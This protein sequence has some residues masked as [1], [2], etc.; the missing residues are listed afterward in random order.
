[1]KTFLTI[2][3][4]L[5][6]LVIIFLTF[7]VS[8]LKAQEF[9]LHDEEFTWHEDDIQYY[10]KGFHYWFDL[11]EAPSTNWRS[12]YDYY[13]GTFNF[14]YELLD[15]PESSPGEYEPFTM[16]FCIWTDGGGKE[17]CGGQIDFSGPRVY[18][19]EE[20]PASFYV[21][22]EED[23]DW[24]DLSTLDRMGHPLWYDGTLLASP[25]NC[26]GLPND[27][28]W[29]EHKDKVF[30]FTIRVTIVVADESGFSGWENYVGG[31]PPA[32]PNY[33]INYY[34]EETQQIV[35]SSDEYSYDESTWY[36]GPDDYLSLTPGVTV[37]FRHKANPG[38]VQTLN[39]PSRPATP[40]FSLDF[41]NVETYEAVSSA[42]EYSENPDM[43]DASDG[44]GGYVDLT[45]GT[46]MYFRK[47]ASSGSFISGIQHLIVPGRPAAPS[48]SISYPDENTSES[49]PSTVQYSEYSDMSDAT[50]GSDSE[51]SL[52][53]GTDLYFRV[54]PTD[55]S[56][57]SENFFLDVPSRPSAPDYTID[58]TNESTN[59]NVPSSDEYSVNSNMSGAVSG[60][61]TKL[62]LTPGTDVYFRTKA[63][64]SAFKSQ[65]KTLTVPDRPATPGFTINPD[66]YETNETVPA[67]TE[68]ST[69]QTDWTA[70]SGT[71]L[72]L[73]SGTTYYFRIPATSGSF[74]SGTQTLVVPS[75]G[76][77]NYTIDF[78]EEMTM[79]NVVPEDEYST[80][81]TTWTSGAGTKIKLTP[82]TTVYFRKKADIAKQQTLVIPV[83]PATPSFAVDYAN[84]RTTATVS[85]A[86][87]YASSPDMSGAIS[88]TG[89]Y[90]T[91]TP[92]NN[93]YIQKK[94]TSGDFTSEVQTLV[95][96]QRPA[97]PVYTI[98]YAA[99][100][101]TESISATVEYSV[102]ADMSAASDGTGSAVSLAPGTD[103]YFRLKATASAFASSVFSL[104]VPARPSSP[105]VTVDYVNEKTNENIDA[106]IEYSSNSNMNTTITGTGAKLD[107]IPGTDLYFRNK[108]TAGAFASSV[109][110]LD[111]PDR[112]AAPAFTI[113][114]VNEKT[115]GSVTSDIEYSTK[116]DFSSSSAGSG[117]KIDLIPG[118]NVYFRKP[119]TASAFMSPTQTLNVPSR[120]IITSLERDST[121]KSP[122]QINITFPTGVT[123]F[124][125]GDI[126]V[127]NGTASN[128]TG[129]YKADIT[130]AEKGYVTVKVPANSVTEGNFVS[131]T[132]SIKYVDKISAID[133]ISGIVFQ[134]Y[135][136]P[137][138]GKVWI[139]I[140]AGIDISRLT[141]EVYN[142]T[143]QLVTVAGNLQENCI[144][145]SDQLKGFYTLRIKTSTSSRI[146]KIVIK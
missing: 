90:V 43:S 34:D 138:E 117:A 115:T 110:T 81:Q 121:D 103:L 25:P 142:I 133:D 42:Y 135:P 116:S 145:L 27:D 141:F 50:S 18:T 131:N 112:P 59:E 22:K 28:Y 111:V 108:S 13:Y 7:I 109:L 14:R 83:R 54:K 20:S 48:Y 51:V 60:N 144:D 126:D 5:K 123:G 91:L 65:I 39:V 136:N 23:I 107:L 30:P 66:T 127:T 146:E 4:K 80:N 124:V 74:L 38:D 3:S 113:D 89:T 72:T 98:D 129:T 17:T 93:I 79:E 102:Y 35:V 87:E 62:D 19:L 9:L 134:L 21:V 47:K 137:S 86:Y 118:I 10:C 96:A 94:A 114:F 92:G 12:P 106:T 75:I 8:N 76:I 78:M 55:S 6:L 99:E 1:M 52:I 58:Y 40:S 41:Y 16:G 132:L 32:A 84:E 69:N 29:N 56:F 97:A 37:Y 63:T 71:T 100:K 95:V 105:V 88:G 77:P 61:G 49:V 44:T 11:G 128:L 36:D 120:P 64:G 119:A 67:T 46:D 33:S 31:T 45:P 73:S 130:P 101:T 82:G 2:I 24:T 122:F 143:G 53:P 104:T 68:Y 85:S 26:P 140:P 125:A 70:G 139:R 15:Q 57:P